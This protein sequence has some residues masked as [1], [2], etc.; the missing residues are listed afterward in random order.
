MPK[1]PLPV[2]RIQG[3]LGLSI[4]LANKKI[5][6]SSAK[7]QNTRLPSTPETVAAAAAT[8]GGF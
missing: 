5:F 7:Q 3:K 1:H 8:V 2:P 6:G 4:L